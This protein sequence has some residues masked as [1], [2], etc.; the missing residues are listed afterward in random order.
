[1]PSKWQ[2]LCWVPGMT[3]VNMT[4]EVPVLGELFNKVHSQYQVL[5]GK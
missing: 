3:A 1:M 4:D 2:A 5:H